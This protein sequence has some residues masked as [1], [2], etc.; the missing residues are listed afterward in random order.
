MKSKIFSIL[1][2]S[3]FLITFASAERNVRYQAFEGTINLQGD[4]EE[5]SNSVS[6]YNVEMYT[7]LNNPCQNIGQLVSTMTSTGNELIITFP[8]TQMTSSGYLLYFYKDGYIGWEQRNIMAKGTLSEIQ[9]APNIYLSKKELAFAPIVNLSVINEIHPNRPIEVGVRTIIDSDTYSA[10][11]DNRVSDV[12]LKESVETKVT[13][14]IFDSN[15][16]LFYT[17]SKIIEI[18]Y[19]S[20][21]ETV[22]IFE[23]FESDETGDY[24]VKVSTEVTDELALD[25]ISQSS[26]SSIKVIPENETEY[27]YSLINNL[28]FNP[29]TP[30]VNETISFSFDYLSAFLDFKEDLT[31]LD[32]EAKIRI[33]RN[34][35]LIEQTTYDLSKENDN[36]NFERSFDEVGS[37]KLIIE[38]EPKGSQ[39]PIES[40][41]TLSSSEKVDFLVLPLDTNPNN[42]TNNDTNQTNNTAPTLFPIGDKTI[43]EKDLLEFTV[44]GTDNEDEDSSLRFAIFGEL[45]TGATFQDGK[46]SWRPTTTQEGNYTLAFLVA[47]KEGLT[48][49]EVITITVN[50]FEDDD[51]NGNKRRKSSRD[52]KRESIS[53]YPTEE[54]PTKN[55]DN[56][57]MLY[58]DQEKEMEENRNIKGLISTLILLIIITIL[59]IILIYLIRIN[60]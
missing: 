35:N 39:I 29:L 18:E 22:F 26:S 9:N 1:I 28:N 3:L 20:S 32:T 41:Y 52:E 36:F 49:S 23:G 10:V 25:Q 54:T 57:V 30:E 12:E 47:D 43:T 40:R 33:Y 4:L 46:F 56:G 27:S 44:F 31:F 6:N 42:N 38:A 59:A 13:L 45:P 51:D 48:D 14:E 50:D 37:Y 19:S 34:S 24:Q 53:L 7:C 55:T 21:M 60:F 58:A 16:N 5:S 8:T 17:D 2:I 15:D 11:E